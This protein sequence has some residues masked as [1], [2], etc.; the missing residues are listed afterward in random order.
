MPW[1]F[2]CNKIIS[3]FI[4]KTCEFASCL[5][6]LLKCQEAFFQQLAQNFAVQVCVFVLSIW[7][8]SKSLV[9]LIMV[10]W[11]Y[12]S[13]HEKWSLVR[14]EMCPSEIGLRPIS[15]DKQ[16]GISMTFNLKW[17]MM[18]KLTALNAEWITALTWA[19]PTNAKQ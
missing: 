16:L 5:L 17:C 19:M 4:R 8:R 7:Q 2:V 18:L 11:L 3:S 15:I 13:T 9:Q 1:N 10:V 14:F 6:V 12:L